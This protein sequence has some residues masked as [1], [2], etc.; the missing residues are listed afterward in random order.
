MNALIF[1]AAAAEALVAAQTGQHRLGPVA[2]TDGRYLLM[3]DVLDE[4]LY[5]GKLDGVEYTV[6]PIES[7]LALLPVSDDDVD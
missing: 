3:A 6:A 2:L 4:P 5:A 7:V 1:N